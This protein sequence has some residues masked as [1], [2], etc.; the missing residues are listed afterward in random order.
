[1]IRR[2]GQIKRKSYSEYGRTATLH[3]KFVIE[4]LVFVL[5]AEVSFAGGD[6]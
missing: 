2:K 3:R 4:G 1:M 6:E 5:I